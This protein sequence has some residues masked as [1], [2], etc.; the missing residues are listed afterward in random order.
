MKPVKV[1]GCCISARRALREWYEMQ[2]PWEVRRQG[3]VEYKDVNAKWSLDRY[4]RQTWISAESTRQEW[5]SWCIIIWE[6]YVKYWWSPGQ[7]VRRESCLRVLRY[8]GSAAIVRRLFAAYSSKKLW[9]TF[10]RW[11]KTCVKWIHQVNFQNGA[12]VFFFSGAFWR[13]CSE[14]PNINNWQTSIY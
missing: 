8:K 10:W 1:R 11:F 6:M 9:F 5:R 3:V 2:S 4:K 12:Y 14:D 13:C 7:M